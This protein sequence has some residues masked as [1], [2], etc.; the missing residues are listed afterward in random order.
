MVSVKSKWVNGLKDLVQVET[1]GMG[2]CEYVNER[3]S[4]KAIR[5][6]YGESA[7]AT[8]CCTFYTRLKTS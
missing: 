2:I 4:W 8:R 7:L 3:Q 1:V 6:V 5:M